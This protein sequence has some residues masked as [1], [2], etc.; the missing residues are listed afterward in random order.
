MTEAT[1]PPVT[2]TEALQ[3]IREALGRLRYGTITLTV[4]DARIVQL[5]ITE[6]RRFPA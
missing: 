3:T 2:S 4:H 1:P 5:D 6:K